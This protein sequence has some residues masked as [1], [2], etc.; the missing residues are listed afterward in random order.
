MVLVEKVSRASLIRRDDIVF[1]SPPPVLRK[2]VS[3]AGGKLNNGD[4]FVK[5]VAAL[6]GDTVSVRADGKVDVVKVLPASLMRGGE[7]GEEEEGGRRGEGRGEATAGGGESLAGGG[8]AIARRVGRGGVTAAATVAGG[9]GRGG[10][11]GRAIPA[12]GADALPEN[13][14]RR[15]TVAEKK[16]LQRGTVFVL[17]DNPSA[18]MDSRV[19]GELDEREIVGH[20]LL[21]VFPPQAFGLFP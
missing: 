2:V 15:I 14:L 6:P 11:G 5:R 3:D 7:G 8:S 10:A 1:F 17:G 18:S 19:W 20:A 16:V 4:L 13:V 21:R 12:A 9:G